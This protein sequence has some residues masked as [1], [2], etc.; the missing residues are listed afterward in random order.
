MLNKCIVKLYK[1]IARLIVLL[2]YMY[3]YI[4]FVNIA[5]LLVLYRSGYV[6]SDCT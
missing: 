5:I 1:T 2:P 4:Y 6:N 3:V